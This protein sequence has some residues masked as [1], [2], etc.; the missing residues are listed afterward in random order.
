[1]TLRCSAS[2]QR[3]KFC[4]VISNMCVDRTLW[5][6][7]N[8]V[9]YTNYR[10]KVLSMSIKVYQ[11]GLFVCPIRVICKRNKHIPVCSHLLYLLSTFVL[12]W[13]EKIFVLL[14]L[15]IFGD[16]LSLSIKGIFRQI[17]QKEVNKNWLISVRL[18]CIIVHLSFQQKKENRVKG[19]LTNFSLTGERRGLCYALDRKRIWSYFR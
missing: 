18:S 14:F 19:N 8:K 15:R 1:M 3:W 11:K 2:F 16:M 10:M 12:P 5:R 6:V 4:V 7:I 17:G 13:P 9:K